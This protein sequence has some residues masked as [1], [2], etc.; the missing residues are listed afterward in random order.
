MGISR[1]LSQL[2]HEV[3]SR[4][5]GASGYFVPLSDYAAVQHRQQGT[6]HS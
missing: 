5:I 1:P 2:S 4:G 6:R 3:P